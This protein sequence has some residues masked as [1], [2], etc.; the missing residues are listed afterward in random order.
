MGTI[1]FNRYMR[2]T[3]SVAVLLLFML[4]FIPYALVNGPSIRL[5]TTNVERCQ[6]YWWSTLLMIQNYVN[7]DQ[8]VSF[9]FYVNSTCEKNKLNFILFFQCLGHVWYLNVDLQ[10]YLM[11]PV[12][13][14]IA[15]K[16]R[17]ESFWLFGAILAAVQINIFF[18][19]F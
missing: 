8:V 12:F 18:V 7:V 16:F 13:I 11:S 6:K 10:L 14:Y 15:W 4:S 19:R 5:L 2:Y 9:I 17:Y 1:Y 3:P